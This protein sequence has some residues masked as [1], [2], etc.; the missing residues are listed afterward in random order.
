ISEGAR[1]LDDHGDLTVIGNSRPRYNVGL[2]A[3]FNWKNVNFSMLWQGVG[4]R[5]YHPG[6]NA[7]VFWGLT[8]GFG[9]S[10]IFRNS[11][12]LDYWRPADETN[13][14]GPNTN[15]YF[16]KPYFSAET[17]KNRRTQSRYVLDASY[18][19]LKNIRLGY[20]LPQDFL[21]YLYIQ[22]AS[23][24]VAGS[25]LITLKHLP[26]NMDPEATIASEPGEGG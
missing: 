3:G 17:N 14:L 1:T 5:G 26:D 19:R 25:N 22:R 21:N 16:P 7:L 10:G 12:N 11:V 2:Q 4:K 13:L 24:Y 15:A 6:G 9:G 8:S 23:I 20:T 18:L